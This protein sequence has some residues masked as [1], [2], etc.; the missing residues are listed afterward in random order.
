MLISPVRL[1]AL[2]AVV[3]L[4]LAVSAAGVPAAAVVARDAGA[5]HEIDTT[6]RADVAEAWESR[7]APAYDVTSGWSGNAE[8]CQAGRPSDEAQGATLD[9]LNFVRA[10]AG[11]DPVDLDTALSKKAQEAALIM[12]ANAALSHDPPKSWDC[13]TKPGAKAAARSVLS[14]TSGEMTAGSAIEMYVDDAGSSNE[15][16]MH[17]RWVLN[18]YVTAVGSGMTSSTNAIDVMG[19]SDDE[20]TDPDWV[21]W[22]TAGWFP[23]QL[24]PGGRW[25]LSSGSATADFSHA[26][27]TVTRGKT[28]LPVTRFAPESGAQPTLVFQVKGPKTPGTYRVLVKHIKGGAHPRH[29]YAVKLFTP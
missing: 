5:V 16:V 7:M 29:G 8:S 12:A 2:V 22:P 19:P 28:T 14:W 6:S 17:R 27:V 18:P 1:S 25:S 13:W 11:L 20:A 15:A 3:T 23:T 21:T 10:M 9:A 4:A 26:V 24:E